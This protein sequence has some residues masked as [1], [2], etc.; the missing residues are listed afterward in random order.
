MQLPPSGYDER[1]RNE[2]YSK[3]PLPEQPFIWGH[4]LETV[5]SLYNQVRPGADYSRSLKLLERIAAIGQG[6]ES[7]SALMLGLGETREE[8]RTVFRDLL[9]VGC[10]RLALRVVF[11]LT[12]VM[13]V[14]GSQHECQVAQPSR[15][16]ELS[17]IARSYSWYA[18]RR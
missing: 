12:L 11:R 2:P 13:T 17:V 9:N 7:K 15:R 4:N 5:S 3:S 14:L 18:R 6:I 8:L 1:E 16:C 10:R